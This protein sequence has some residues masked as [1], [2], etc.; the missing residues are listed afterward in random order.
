MIRSVN[1]GRLEQ[2]V[3]DVLD[4]PSDRLR[5]QLLGIADAQGVKL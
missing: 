3:N 1:M 5:D 4:N 2:A